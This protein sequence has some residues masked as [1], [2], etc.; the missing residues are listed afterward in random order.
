[1]TLRRPFYIYTIELKGEMSFPEEKKTLFIYGTYFKTWQIFSK[2]MSEWLSHGWI[3]GFPQNWRMS[4]KED[5]DF[6]Q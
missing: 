3:R 5:Y 1:M 4:H 6:L 2:K